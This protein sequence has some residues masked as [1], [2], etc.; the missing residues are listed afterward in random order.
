MNL[1]TDS[2]T[3]PHG[4]WDQGRW[5]GDRGRQV[6]HTLPALAAAEVGG[7]ETPAACC[8]LLK[9]ASWP[10]ADLWAA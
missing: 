9:S 3:E 2:G 6:L 10:P 1:P 5:R 4:T 7:A 8:D